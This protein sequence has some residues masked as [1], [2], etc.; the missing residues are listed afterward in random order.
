[1]FKGVLF[2]N[3]NNLLQQGQVASLSINRLINIS[4]KCS[5]YLQTT[6]KYTANYISTVR[7]LI[8]FWVWKVKKLSSYTK[9]G[10]RKTKKEQNKIL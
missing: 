10:I 8:Y 3:P 6:L 5:K 2:K 7:Y 1:M 9:E 4:S